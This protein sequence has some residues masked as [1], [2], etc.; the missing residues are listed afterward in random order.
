M[1]ELLLSGAACSVLTYGAVALR[2]RL[3]GEPWRD[4]IIRPSGAGGPGPRPR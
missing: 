4:T 2:L 1:L 3:P